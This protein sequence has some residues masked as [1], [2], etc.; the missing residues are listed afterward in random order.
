[1][2][3]FP[4]NPCFLWEGFEWQM[5]PPQLLHD[6]R[7]FSVNWAFQN[8]RSGGRCVHLTDFEFGTPYA[9]KFDMETQ[10][11]HL[12]KMTF[13]KLSAICLVFLHISRGVVV[14]SARRS[15]WSWIFVNDKI[16]KKRGTFRKSKVSGFKKH[17]TFSGGACQISRQDVPWNSPKK[18]AGFSDV[19]L[20]ASNNLRQALW[21]GKAFFG[22]RLK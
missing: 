21:R 5:H 9:Q 6:S 8:M 15:S 19:R 16:S 13:S 11:N 2:P 10:V 12:E 14:F 18:K 4:M 20:L 1:M 22:I 3:W 7:S 17:G